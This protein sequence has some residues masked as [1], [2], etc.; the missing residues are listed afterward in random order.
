M[1]EKRLSCF[2]SRNHDKHFLLH[3]LNAGFSITRTL[4]LHL[5]VIWTCFFKAQLEQNTSQTCYRTRPDSQVNGCWCVDSKKPSWS[6]VL[7]FSP[8]MRW[9]QKQMYLIWQ[10]LAAVLYSFLLPTGSVRRVLLRHL[11]AASAPVVKPRQLEVPEDKKWLK[12]GTNKDNK[13]GINNTQNP[14]NMIFLNFNILKRHYNFILAVYFCST[15]YCWVSLG[16]GRP[17]ATTG[18]NGVITIASTGRDKRKMFKG[19]HD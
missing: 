4:K 14:Q 16:S 1:F 6:D 18:R 10:K 13:I 12:H 15:T 7:S 8:P 17:N 3:A 19:I 9:K 11:D 5:E 2:L